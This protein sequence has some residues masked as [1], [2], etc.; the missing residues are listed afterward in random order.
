MDSRKCQTARVPRQSRGTFPVV[1][2]R[3][4]SA[5]LERSWT[6]GCGT[7]LRIGD[8]TD[9]AK[10]PPLRSVYRLS[11]TYR[12]VTLRTTARKRRERESS[13]VLQSPIS[14]D[15]KYFAFSL[16]QNGQ[17]LLYREK[18]RRTRSLWFGT[19]CFALTEPRPLPPARQLGLMNNQ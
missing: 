18:R 8:V 9:P 2:R 3:G 15:G 5:F 7:L 1:K 16:R 13:A 11:L 19:M 6:G 14:A 17:T 12:A 4:C 10:G